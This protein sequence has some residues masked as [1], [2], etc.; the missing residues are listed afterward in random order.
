MSVR[1]D[2]CGG[3]ALR[4]FGGEFH[5]GAVGTEFHNPHASAYV[6]SVCGGFD[7]AKVGLE[8]RQCCDG[9]RGGVLRVEGVAIGGH[10]SE[11]ADGHVVA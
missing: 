4:L 7:E 5:D 9:A 3:G 11:H 1:G 10:S 2:S 6:A 8:F